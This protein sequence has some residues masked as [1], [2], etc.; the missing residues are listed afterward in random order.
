LRAINFVKNYVILVQV[1]ATDLCRFI[2]W[3]ITNT[4][5]IKLKFENNIKEE[6]GNALTYTQHKTN[7]VIVVE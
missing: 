1:T 6:K 7:I 2:C 5:K 3:N 4:V